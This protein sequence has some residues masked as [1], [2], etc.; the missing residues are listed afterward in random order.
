[1]N[2]KSTF[3]IMNYGNGNTAAVISISDHIPVISGYLM[4]VSVLLF[5]PKRTIWLMSFEMLQRNGCKFN[6]IVE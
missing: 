1:M 4:P 5:N 3:I 2:T 6:R